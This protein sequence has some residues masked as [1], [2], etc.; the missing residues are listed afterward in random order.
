MSLSQRNGTSLGEKRHFFTMGLEFAPNY[1]LV[2]TKLQCNEGFTSPLFGPKKTGGK[3]KQG[4]EAGLIK[5]E[6][7]ANKSGG[8]TKWGYTYK[9]RGTFSFSVVLVQWCKQHYTK[10]IC[11]ISTRCNTFLRFSVVWCHLSIFFREN[12]CNIKDAARFSH[13]AV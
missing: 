3:S 8:K 4:W 12:N 2:C 5:V 6:T 7:G 9:W 10:I 13:G 1:S 11:W